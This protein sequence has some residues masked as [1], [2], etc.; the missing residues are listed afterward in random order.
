LW[1]ADQHFGCCHCQYLSLRIDDYI[2]QSKAQL[3]RR[4]DCSQ[5][6][7]VRKRFAVKE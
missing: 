2:V 6:I 1:C 3:P 5:S 7:I 4:G